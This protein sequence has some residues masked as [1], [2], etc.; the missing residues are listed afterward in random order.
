MLYCPSSSHDNNCPYYHHNNNSLALKGASAVSQ[1]QYRRQQ[2]TISI[3][4]TEL[5]L[6]N[7]SLEIARFYIE[8][9]PGI[10]TNI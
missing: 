3:P 8:K 10:S 7:K 6:I 1:R 2:E 9:N 5:L 4:Q